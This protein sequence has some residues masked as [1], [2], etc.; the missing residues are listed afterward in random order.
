MVIQE[1]DVVISSSA[2]MTA[3]AVSELVG[4]SVVSLTS[5]VSAVPVGIFVGTTDVVSTSSMTSDA[6]GV[7]VGESDVSSDTT[8]DAVGTRQVNADSDIDSDTSMSAVPVGIFVGEVTITST[9]SMVADPTD[10]QG[11]AARTILGSATVT[12]V[13]TIIPGGVARLLSAGTIIALGTWTRSFTSTGGISLGGSADTSVTMN[14]DL[15]ATWVVEGEI[16]KE[17]QFRWNVNDGILKWYRVEGQCQIATC[18]SVNLAAGDLLCDNGQTFVQNVAAESVNEVCAKLKQEFINRPR[19]WPIKSIKRFSQPVLLTDDEV[20]SQQGFNVQCTELLEEESFCE[21]PECLEFCVEALPLVRMGINVTIQQTFLN[22]MPS[23]GLAFSGSADARIVPPSQVGSGGMTLGGTADAAVSHWEYTMSGGLT[24]GGVAEIASSSW[25][26]TMSGGLTMGGTSDVAS[27]SHHYEASGGFSLGGDGEIALAFSWMPVGGLDLGGNSDAEITVAHY[28]YEGEGGLSLGGEAVNLPGYYAYEA[29][30]G[31]NLS[32]L[33]IKKSTSW[34][35]TPEGG[36]SLGGEAEAVKLPEPHTGSGGFALGGSGDPVLILRHMPIGG[37]TLGGEA[38]P[39]SSPGWTWTGNGGLSIG[40]SSDVVSSDKGLFVVYMGMEISLPLLESEINNDLIDFE[41]TVS[42]DEET[43][44]TS[45]GCGSNEQV[46][47]LQHNLDN[48]KVFSDFLR[49]N[50]FKFPDPLSLKFRKAEDGWISNT[51]LRGIGF[52]GVSYETWKL[53][54][55]WT[56]ATEVS[57]QDLDVYVWRFSM[58]V[59]RRIESTNEDFDTRLLYSFP[60]DSV[61]GSN[62]TF[63]D[64]NF[65]VDLDSKLA[66]P[67]VNTFVY[68]NIFYDEIGLFKGS[69]WAN[70]NFLLGVT[71]VDVE[72]NVNLVNFEPILP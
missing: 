46:I 20:A 62:S 41:D 57:G 56:C 18:D 37:L 32:G 16:R 29:T 42:I 15:E 23:G 13:G 51:T 68:T 24:M 50:N 31:L 67:D 40:G 60:R 8:V 1:G 21:E 14:F 63:F 65:E 4:D 44:T 69:T 33:A 70:T 47:S 2:S 19:I 6:V 5:S 10:I 53:F 17:I 9:T 7:F 36:L 58:L 49:R 52:D 28:E 55:E 64:F 27:S 22:H 54:F 38:D 61:C 25:S 26:Y 48:S 35:W 34:N 66:L 12:A 39:V 45:C 11:G 59:R 3:D 71:E 30:G 72:T 43:I